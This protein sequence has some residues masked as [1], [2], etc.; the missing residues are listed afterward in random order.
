MSPSIDMLQ[1][2]SDAWNAHDLDQL[3]SFMAD[4]CIFHAV[5]GP[6]ML[7]R[8]FRGAEDVRAGFVAAWKT[9]PDAAWLDP[10]HCVCGNRGFTESTFVGTRQD[11]SRVH[12]RMVDIFTFT[13]D[14][15]LV[16]NAFR[17]ERVVA[18]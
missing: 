15:I 18:G 3:M 8:T 9:F 10:V 11:G 13:G 17:K 6:D 4:D 7:G 5:S 14:L 16:K 12:A 2:F 1:R